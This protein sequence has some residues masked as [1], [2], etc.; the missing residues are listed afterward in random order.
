MAISLRHVQFGFNVFDE[1]LLGRKLQP[2]EA[3]SGLY[4]PQLDL[5]RRLKPAFL[6][7][8]KQE[9][10]GADLAAVVWHEKAGAGNSVVLE[11]ENAR[12][13]GLFQGKII[14][15]FLNRQ[16]SEV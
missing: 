12:L 10:S 6:L 3:A 8:E 11:Q 13:R 14:H 1:D 9:R 15:G 2:G 7:Q 4:C 16:F 5:S